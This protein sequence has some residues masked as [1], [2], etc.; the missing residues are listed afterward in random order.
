MKER[1]RTGFPEVMGT[2]SRINS[3]TKY[4][5][6]ATMCISVMDSLVKGRIANT[7]N[8]LKKQATMDIRNLEALKNITN[9]LQIRTQKTLKK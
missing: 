6:K 7:E 5:N 9:T 1:I 2:T 3:S 8:L 4:R